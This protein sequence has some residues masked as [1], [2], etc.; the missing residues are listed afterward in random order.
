MSSVNSAPPAAGA[1]GNGQE[2]MPAQQ[3]AGETQAPAQV[4]RDSS[5]ESVP[6]AHYEP[7]PKPESGGASGKPYVVWSS[8]PSQKDAG[9]R[10]PEE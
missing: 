7:T 6:I 3:A 4:E 10:G 1:S 9:S 8:T 5:H 2:T